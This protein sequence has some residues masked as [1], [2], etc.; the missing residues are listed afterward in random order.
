MTV[1]EELW[2]IAD[3]ASVDYYLIFSIENG[4]TKEVA[5]QWAK[6]WKDSQRR[7]QSSGEGG[8]RVD[9][10]PNEPRPTFVPCD[11][12]IEPVN[13]SETRFFRTCPACAEAIKKGMEVTK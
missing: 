5:R 1:A 9:I 13:L 10:S 8:G 6:D 7:S 4:C 11:I 12:C 2:P 3:E